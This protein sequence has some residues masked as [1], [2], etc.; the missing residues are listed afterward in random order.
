MLL[1]P[2]QIQTSPNITSFNIILPYLLLDTV[3]VCGPPADCGGSIT[4]HIDNPNSHDNGDAI[5]AI[6]T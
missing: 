3:M 6:N 5:T 4:F 2:L 1:C